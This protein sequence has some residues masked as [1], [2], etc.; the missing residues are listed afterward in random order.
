[1]R[2]PS[3]I[4]IGSLLLCGCGLREKRRDLADQYRQARQLLNYG[5]SEEAGKVS[6]AAQVDARSRGALDWAVQFQVLDG[7]VFG[8]AGRADEAIVLLSAIQPPPGRPDIR[9]RRNAALANEICVQAQRGGA[10]AGAEQFLNAHKLLDDAMQAAQG[11]AELQSEALLRRAG[12][13]YRERKRDAAETEIHRVI[14]LTRAHKLQ[15]LQAS[16]LVTLVSVRLSMGHA[17]DGLKPGMEA[18]AIGRAIGADSVVLKSL[19]NLGLCYIT[20]G[21]YDRALEYMNQAN[22]VA[23]QPFLRDDRRQVYTNTGNLYFYLRDYGEAAANY[24]RALEQARQV[25]NKASIAL[26]LTNLGEA[27]LEQGDVATASRCNSEALE[28]R[29]EMHDEAALRRSQLLAA[30]ILLAQEKTEA[31]GKAFQALIDPATPDSLIWEVHAGLARVFALQ[32]R[33]AAAERE[34]HAAIANVESSRA[35]LKLDQSRITFQSAVSELYS[36]YVEFMAES[37][38]SLEA[39]LAADRSRAETL[40]HRVGASAERPRIDPPKLQMASRSVLL[41][42]WL[43]DRGSYL[44]FV[45]G[46]GVEQFKLPPRREIEAAVEQYQHLIE[47]PRDALRDGGEAGV[48]LWRMLIGPAANRIPKGAQVLLVLDRKLHQ[49]NFETLIAPDPI[50]HFWIEDVTLRESPSL[51]SMS[52]L[53]AA[54]GADTILLMGD[55]ALA[56]TD[57]PPLAHSAEEIAAIS[58]LFPV[59]DRV[60]LTGAAATAPAY[61]QSVPTRFRFIHFA[62]HATANWASP[63][64]SAVVF[65][66]SGDDYRLYARDVARTP[67]SAELVTVSACRSA[68]A[69]AYAGEGLVGFSW[70]FLKAGARNVIAGLWKVED[71]STA[72]IMEQL[73][74]DLRLGRSPADALRNAKLGL[75]HSGTV[76]RRPFYWAPFMLYTRVR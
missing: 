30:R 51:A 27:A 57:F 50:P 20:L 12:C 18:L 3:R 60:V 40:L 65:A 1:M 67:L 6:R 34:F 73:Y 52:P 75:L 36:S 31:S 8:R 64:D 68:G 37:G 54:R 26:L 66:R 23:P 32:G 4:V 59:P 58:E 72:Q 76:Y 63:L 49:L 25:Q 53:E 43:A 19:V 38:H 70:A 28:I 41:S 10:A 42:Y 5:N 47:S 45:G 24:S 16:A 33:R 62:A 9:S 61:L 56:N 13:L 71:A 14:D 35:T 48:N 21:D 39:F 29:R 44:W 7:E 46:A 11:D 17:E 55:P 15:F 69:H 2:L 22:S 74:R